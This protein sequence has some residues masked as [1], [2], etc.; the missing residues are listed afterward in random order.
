[1]FK[2]AISSYKRIYSLLFLS[3]SLFLLFLFNI[4]FKSARNAKS[5]VFLE[6]YV[7]ILV[8][9]NQKLGMTVFQLIKEGIGD[10]RNVINIEELELGPVGL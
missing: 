9:L 2:I 8:S 6:V 5:V 7:L 4:A 1:M 3:F 10:G